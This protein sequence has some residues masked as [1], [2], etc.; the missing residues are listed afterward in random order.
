MDLDEK[1]IRGIKK[2]LNLLEPNALTTEEFVKAFKAVLKQIAELEKKLVEANQI[3]TAELKTEFEKLKRGEDNEYT[4]LQAKTETRLEKAFKEQ[5][6]ALNFIRDKVRNLKHGIDGQDGKTP[7]KEELTALI[8]ELIPSLELDTPE[9][10]ANKLETLKG[11][12]KLKLSAIDE[13]E[14]RLKELEDRPLRVGGGG[15]FSKIAMDQHILNWTQFGAGDDTTTEFTL[16]YK[17]NPISSLEIMVGGAQ[18]F[19]TDDWTYASSTGVV[20]FL[21]A[22]P[23]GAKIRQKCLR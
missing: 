10:L 15:G 23:N 12:A 7:T 1:Q 21:T 14:E 8:S 18:L 4:G 13:L 20:T 19:E 9:E 17:P 5:A 3:K 22:P 6:N 11:K 16:S 2:L